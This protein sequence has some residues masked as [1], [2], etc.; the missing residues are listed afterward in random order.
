M[1]ST[2]GFKSTTATKKPNP[3]TCTS[4]KKLRN[5]KMSLGGMMIIITVASVCSLVIDEIAATGIVQNVK[6]VIKTPVNLM[7]NLERDF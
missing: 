3:G 6:R 7:G 4:K 2:T 5:I 1:D